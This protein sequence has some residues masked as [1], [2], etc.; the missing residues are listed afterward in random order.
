MHNPSSS[1]TLTCI[2]TLTLIGPKVD[3]EGLGAVEPRKLVDFV[4]QGYLPTLQ[5]VENIRSYF[6][7]EKVLKKKSLTLNT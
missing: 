7:L 3:V 4:K 1:P 5:E 6:N 2:A